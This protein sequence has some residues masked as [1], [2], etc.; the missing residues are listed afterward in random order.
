[1]GN[2]FMLVVNAAN[3]AGDLEWV[4]A[5]AKGLDVTIDDRSDQ[6]SLLAL[7]G[8]KSIDILQP[9]TTTDLG[10]IGTYAW[11]RGAIGGID[12][13]FSRTGYTGEP[14][15]ELYFDSS[16]A[17]ARTVWDAIMKSG[18]PHGLQPVGLGARDTLRLEMAYCLYGNDIGRST[19]PLEAG[20]GW[21]TKLD[22]GEFI[23]RDALVN[24][25]KIGVARKLTGFL[26]DDAKALPRPHY[27][28]AAGGNV[29]GEV[30]SGTISPTLGRGIGLGYVPAQYAAPGQKISVYIRDREVPATTVATPF[31]RKGA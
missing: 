24:A 15:F 13:L 18:T 25:K 28:L 12:V 14:G 29:V 20:L 23:G 11:S 5:A 10:A 2:S 8:P 9:L 7:Q 21:I 22:K 17:S 27:R 6:I 16:P 3:R 31:V 19:N 30:T 26:P 4:H 1:M